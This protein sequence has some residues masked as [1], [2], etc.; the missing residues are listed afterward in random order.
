MTKIEVENVIR[1]GS[2]RKVDAVKYSAMRDAYLAVLPPAPPGLTPGE[3]LTRL[4]ARLDA[5]S[6]P[7]GAKA[8]WWAKTVQL[9]LEAKKIVTRAASGPVR[10]W[11][12]KA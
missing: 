6:F 1:P 9:D 3:I 7:G 2:A 11:K 4:V 5:E 12:C 8:G 10:L